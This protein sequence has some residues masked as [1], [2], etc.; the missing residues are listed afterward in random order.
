MTDEMSDSYWCINHVT[1]TGPLISQQPKH[2]YWPG[3]G[4]QAEQGRALNTADQY[5]E[6]EITQQT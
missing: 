4:W 6:R 3:L 2:K 1:G 5:K